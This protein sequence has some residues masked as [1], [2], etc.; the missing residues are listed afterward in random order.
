[1]SNDLHVMHTKNPHV[2]FE[3]KRRSSILHAIHV[4]MI[5]SRPLH[6]THKHHIRILKIHIQWYITHPKILKIP[7]AKPQKQIYSCLA[8]ANRVHQVFY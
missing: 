5:I 2:V 3:P 6:T 1:M 8:T 4:T 7:V